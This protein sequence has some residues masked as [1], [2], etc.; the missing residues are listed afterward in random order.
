MQMDPITGFFA[1]LIS[2]LAICS[3]F[4]VI[5]IKKRLDEQTR[6]LEKMLGAISKKNEASHVAPHGPIPSVSTSE[7]Q[8]MTKYGITMAGEEYC[9]KGLYYPTLDRA[10]AYA[11]LLEGK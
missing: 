4:A 8:L 7:E 5:G 10:V 11:K 3:M 6:V 9:F 1:L 2:I